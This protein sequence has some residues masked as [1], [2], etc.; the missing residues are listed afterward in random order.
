MQTQQLFL[1]VMETRHLSRRNIE[2][3]ALPPQAYASHEQGN[4]SEEKQKHAM[5]LT[6]LW[7]ERART[8]IPNPNE[9]QKAFAWPFSLGVCC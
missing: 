3:A 6:R 8:N 1:L 2:R 7:R 5:L 9:I 4:I